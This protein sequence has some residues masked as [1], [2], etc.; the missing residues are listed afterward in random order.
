MKSNIY[1]GILAITELFVV[2]LLY[3]FSPLSLKTYL[4][5]CIIWF[6]LSVIFEHYKVGCALIWT[7]I[8]AQFKTLITAFALQLMLIFHNPNFVVYMIFFDLFMFFFSVALNRTLRIV[9][10]NWL[11][12]KTLIIGTNYEA[13]RVATVANNN[14]FALTLVKGFIKWDGEEIYHD[15]KNEKAVIVPIYDFEEINDVIKKEHIEQVIVAIENGTKEDYDII[16]RTL[17]NQVEI[18]K[19]LPQ[20]N[21]TITFNSQIQDFDGELLIS[22]SSRRLGWLER[23]FKRVIDLISGLLGVLLLIPISI[24]VKLM[25][26][27]NG[28]HDPIFFTQERIGINGEPI[29]I[30]KYRSM[31]P[32]AEKIL[33]ELMASDPKIKEEYLTNKKLV[34]DPRVT[35]VGAFLRKT[36]LDEFPQF[37]NVLKGEMS[38]VGPRPYLYRE[39]EDMDIYY[40][41]II[42]C[43]PG[44]TGMWQANGRSDV[45]FVERCKFDDYY[46]K[47]WSIGLDMIIIYKTV[48]S[49]IYG[50]GAL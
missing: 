23:V 31:V 41:T 47:N 40:E 37:I 4:K 29:K 18:I 17:F 24:V 30:Y 5:V 26:L 43:K 11:G 8:K 33:E 6:F 12:R 3:S 19:V 7:E 15:D 35:K 20:I 44:I 38:L 39:I 28:D 22:T 16:S 50:R 46:Y 27:S 25:N 49:V 21:F 2:Y 9:L 10:R 36:S 14:R 32:D 45:G 13:V 1:S 48:K 42:K 34:N